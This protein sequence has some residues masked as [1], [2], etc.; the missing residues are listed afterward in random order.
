MNYKNGEEILPPEL[1]KIL[2]SYAEGELIYIPKKDKLRSRWGENCGTRTLII[3]RNTEIYVQYKAGIKIFE[4]AQSFFLSE[5][6]IKKI[7]RL[8]RDSYNL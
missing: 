4:L 6:S 2:Q 8:V 3:K 7:I 1:L 5:D